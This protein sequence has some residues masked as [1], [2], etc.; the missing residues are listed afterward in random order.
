MGVAHWDDVDWRHG[1]KGAMD[2]MFQRLG[3]AAGTV[4]VGVNRARVA[5][6][7]L[8][9]PPHSHGASE[10]LYFVLAGS[11]LAW[12]DDEVHEV[13]P[14]DCVIHR[15]DEHE[16]TFVAGPEGLEYLVFGTRH[17]TEIG[18]LPRSRA[19]RIGWP[20]VEGRDDDPWETEAEAAPL[21]HGDPAPRPENILNV[22]EVELEDNGAMTSA[23]LATRERSTLSGLHWEQ[24]AAGRRGSPPHCHSE[25]EEVFVILDGEATLELWPAPVKE[26]RGARSETIP[27]RAG[28]VVARPPGSGIAHSFLAGPDGVTMLIYGTRTPNDMAWFPRSSKIFWR[29]LGVIGRIE[30]LEYGDGEPDE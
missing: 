8:P 13:R 30:S 16:H 24:L 22:D 23:P 10:E 11:G 25:E 6:G 12:Q 29:G 7:K 14:L 3:D 28:H 20:W 17:R 5:P 19:I 21:E 18:W 2:V 27:L 26:A 4:G 1:A 9:T 15:P